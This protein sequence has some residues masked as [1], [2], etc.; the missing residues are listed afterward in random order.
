MDIMRR[1]ADP[2]PIENALEINA[3]EYFMRR[4]DDMPDRYRGRGCKP[5]I[6]VMLSS[7]VAFNVTIGVGIRYS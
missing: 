3:R 2:M 7:Y 5:C 1:C 6:V 4:A